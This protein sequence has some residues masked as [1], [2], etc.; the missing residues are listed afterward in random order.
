MK[1]V[2]DAGTT[3]VLTAEGR[4]DRAGAAAFLNPFDQRALRVALDLRVAGETITAISLG[5]APAREALRIALALG[6]DRAWHLT[7]EEFAGSDTVATSR[8]LARAIRRS[9]SE[10][11][12][13]G[14]FST[15]AGT[16]FVPASTA[17]RLGYSVRTG[18]RAI[19]RD[20]D[21]G[22]IEVTSD[23]EDGWLRERVR[24]PVLL[25]VGEKIAKI[26]PPEPA[27]LA[28]ISDGRIEPFR[29]AELGLTAAETGGAGSPTR[30]VR[31]FG[32]APVRH[33]I[34][35]D[36]GSVESQARA[37]AE[38]L[39]EWLPAAPASAADSVHGSAAPRPLDDA[40]VLVTNERGE[41][42]TRALPLLS[43]VRL[44]SPTSPVAAWWLGPPPDPATLERIAG[45]G[46]SELRIATP[47]SIPMTVREAALGVARIVEEAPNVA[48]VLTAGDR[49]GR[50][51]AAYVS[52]LRELGIVSG[53]RGIRA[54]DAGPL[55]WERESF[56]G[57]YLA[58]VI[59][60]SRPALAVARAGAF[61]PAPSGAAPV[62]RSTVHSGLATAEP[63][64]RVDEGREVE[65]RI[66]DLETARCLV[67]VGTGVGGP[68][69]IER[70]RP[71]L[72]AWG[73]ALGATR[74]VV[75][76]GWVPR[77][78]QIGLTGRT[79]APELLILLGV[80]GSANHA[81]GWRRARAVVAVNPDPTAP[82]FDVSDVGIVGRWEE[83]WPPLTRALT[84]LVHRLS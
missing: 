35:L 9:R 49:F 79:V 65:G 72:E 17:A 20:R 84:P 55:R 69:G 54:E 46:A 12:L 59:V 43:E 33:R 10:L 81:I 73:A 29:P 6:A 48:T 77:Y 51:V 23:T 1:S 26:L 11:V 39:G 45:A 68:A 74:R 80:R 60:R 7:G 82:I 56:G 24:P 28:A 41:L 13:A 37:A 40:G 27:R 42:E 76:V 64:E 53:V 70:L 8:A 52:G 62:L 22:E 66:G 58:E 61:R 38:L 47:H 18:V 83:V 57:R 78:R 25:A 19:R 14:E 21:R 34:R 15:D 36:Q 3:A 44:R 71:D 31:V 63:S 32:E 30:V 75:D 50:D 67:V 16:G 2:P 5:P 4:F